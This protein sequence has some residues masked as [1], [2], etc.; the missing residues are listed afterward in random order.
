MQ[1]IPENP[2]LSLRAAC[3]LRPVCA[4]VLLALLPTLALAAETLT[5]GVFAY[6]PKP[7]MEERFRQLAIYLD[8][9]LPDHRVVLEI[10]DQ[11]EMEAALSANRLD[12]VFTNPS[13]FVLL[14]HRNRLS[15][16]IATLIS[17]ED[18]QATSALGGVILAPSGREDIRELNDLRGKRIAIPGLKFLG[19]YQTQ[20]YE[21]LQAGIR[22]PNDAQLVEVGGHD[23]VVAALLEGKADAGFVR[24]GIVEAMQR[25]GKLP[26]GRLK[27]INRQNLPDFPYVVSTRLYPEW[28]FA[29]LP[30]VPESVVKRIAR[31]LLFIEADMPVAEAAGIEGFAIPGDYQTV[32]EL[33]RK[34]RLPPYEMP[35]FHFADVWQRYRETIFMGLASGGVIVFLVTRLLV[36]NRRLRRQQEKQEASERR[37]N[38]I[39]KGANL[40]TWE[41]EIPSGTLYFNEHWARMLGYAPDAIPS[42]IDTWKQLV[43]PS[44]WETINAALNPHLA[45]LQ[46][47]YTCQHR[48]QHKEGRWVWVLDAGQVIERDAE[49]NPVRAS[50]IHMDISPLKEIEIALRHREQ[51]MQTLLD[52]MDD[53]VLVIDTAGRIAESHWPLNDGLAPPTDDWIG[54]DCAEILPTSL[55]EIIGELMGEL[56]LDASKPL[57]REFEWP[58]A[59]GTRWFLATFSALKAPEDRHPRGFLCV[60]RDITIRKHE[61]KALA[62]SRIEVDKLARRNQLLLDAAG[63][64]IYGVDL[65]GNI[66]FINP[67]ALAM[68]GLTEVEALGRNSHELFH[69]QRLDGIPYP[70]EECPLH[71][72]LVD[73]LRREVDE[74]FC[75]R[76]GELFF[77][78]LVTTSV[79]DEGQCVG[80]EVVFLDVSARKAMEMELTRLATTDTLTN[81]ANRRHFMSQV[82]TEFSRIQRFEQPATLL[83]LDLDHFKTINDTYGHAAGDSVLIAFAATVRGA[84]RKVDVVGR[85][86]GE[87]FAVLLPGSEMES[88]MRFAE[89]LRNLVAELRITSGETSLGVTVSIGIASLRGTAD[90][91]DAVLARADVALYRAKANG[92]NRVEGEMSSAEP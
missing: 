2:V 33:T 6:R 21:L 55:T 71:Q 37:L 18:G 82:E 7:V 28:A 29:A 22:L 69:D 17:R 3:F 53:V 42:H 56:I 62:L 91:P 34:L 58:F 65:A 88:A 74:V 90:T 49:G 86:G 38:L 51:H 25:E 72:T 78:H 16:A 44:D 12:L 45:G 89:R 10:L 15:G 73:G 8:G 40:G 77:V 30:H 61:E 54:R 80:A 47:S 20:A 39:I 27:L 52:S 46:E 23:A 14:R 60:A 85:L 76:N 75:R 87:E 66:T 41:W 43:H 35:E 26:E 32:E 79:I 57:H 63:E 24:T 5:L 92:R 70:Q 9:A 1:R 11:K 81:V 64:G 48:L 67:T 31:T 36:N 50:G 19:G 68:L 4:V 59:N 13:H 83:M 84:L